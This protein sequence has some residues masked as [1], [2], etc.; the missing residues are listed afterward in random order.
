MFRNYIISTLRNFSKSKFY[1]ALNIIGLSI[2][3]AAF[4]FILMFVRDE[5][6]YDKHNEHWSRI[7][8]LESDFSIS[9]S[10]E[11]FAIVPVPMAPAIK[12]EFPEV[13]SF[14]RFQGAGNA[15]M[16]AN[17]KE[18]YEE[19]IY[20]V[21]STVFEIFT[22]EFIYGS[23]QNALNE[24]NTIVLT[25]KLAKKYFGD[26]N[27]VGEFM[28]SGSG[29]SYKVTGVIENQPQN[30]HLKYDGLISQATLVTAVGAE[31][32]NSM[33]PGRFWNIGLYAYVL[34]NKNAKIESI[35]EKFD[36]FYQKY[37]APIGEMINASFTLRTTPL[38]ETHYARGLDSD[39]PT[40]NM[41]YVYIFSA[42]ALFI[43]VIAAI[44]YMN[45]ATARSARRAREV[46]MRKVAGAHRGQLIGQFISESVILAIFALIIAVV[47]VIIL[48]PDFNHIADKQFTISTLLDPSAIVIVLLVALIIG[49]ISGSYPAFYLSSFE[50]VAVLKGGT[51]TGKKSGALRRVLVVVQFFIA[52]VMIIATVVVSDQ[53]SFL[54]KT[55]LG[56]NKEN[57]VVMQ[58]QDSAFRSKHESFKK[59]L[60]QHPNIISAT[61]STGIPGNIS[62]IQVMYVERDT[63]M[64]E[65]ALILAQVDYDYL[66]TMGMEIVQGRAFDKSM[67]TDDTAAV[68]IN[69]TGVK[70]LG[71]TDNPIGKRIDYEIDLE[72]NVGR[73][74]KVIGVVKDF[75]FR[76]LHNEV[77]PVILFISR[78]P[79]FFMSAR[80]T[81]TDI[82]GTLGFIEEKWHDF[83]AERPFDYEFLD[84]SMDEMY[85]AEQKLGLIFRIA[86]ILTIFIALLGLLGLSSFI[87]E[88]RSKEIGIRK[89]LGSSV[90]GVLKLLYREFILLILIAFVLAIPIAWWQLDRWLDDTFIYRDAIHWY[91]FVIAGVF[92]VIIGLATISFHIVRAASG[93][94]VD[95]IKYE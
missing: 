37:M 12:L 22:H 27:P 69:E 32:F 93:N 38:A 73:P 85:Q 77:E 52:I 63:A 3:F 30:T 76:S 29:R 13:E 92:A 94:P 7:H 5:I 71:W 20:F 39:Q 61:N 14:V 53:L 31:D 6:S 2:G 46:G 55:D 9:N 28:T 83:G 34:L 78:F 87:A 82:R 19:D 66:E 50:P 60:V 18:Y 26:I 72:G 86:A 24:P 4:I 51:R 42:V 23:P 47:L 44:N 74:M 25:E 59:E 48:L 10:Q 70:T 41:A 68:I 67:G 45:M 21:D 15:L 81:G 75:H 65:D 57:V 16:K 56:F 11:Q 89:V 84:K 43:L 36:P 95:A 49:V 54:Q 91:S 8:R 40:G 88:Q 58:M 64:V 80:I 35:H 90:E 17:E 1:S 62:W 33:E 79:R